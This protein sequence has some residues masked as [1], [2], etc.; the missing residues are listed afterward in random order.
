[1]NWLKNWLWPQ[2]EKEWTWV[3]QQQA[4]LPRKKTPLSEIN[5]AVLDVETTGL[6]A[7]IDRILSIAVVPVLGTTIQ[8]SGCWEGWVH[9]TYFD[10]QSMRIHEITPAQSNR[11]VVQERDML[12]LL[13]Q[14]FGH[15]VWV[16]HFGSIDYQFLSA[17]GKRVGLKLHQPMIDTATLLARVDDDFRDPTAITPKK[18]QLDAVCKHLQLPEPVAHTAS[19]DA[20]ATAMV[21]VKLLHQ[22]QKRGATQWSDLKQG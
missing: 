5:F 17:V 22:L 18:W 1:M 2:M 9:Q 14:K 8:T 4:K 10:P 6:D 12:E 13:F 3:A 16:G 7:K 21:F 15:C 11:A 19:G 20:L